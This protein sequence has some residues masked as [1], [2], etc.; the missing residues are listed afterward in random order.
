MALEH[1]I[2]VS[3]NERAGTGYQLTRRFD[4]SI[5]H[6][7]R[8]THQQIYRTLARMADQGLVMF[9]EEPQ[10]GKPDRKVYSVTDGGRAF[11]SEWVTTA[12]KPATLRDELAVKI[13]GARPEDL[14]ALADEI[15]RHREAHAERVDLYRS[16]EKNDYP[17]PSTLTGTALQQQLVLRGG[18][19]IE[20]ALVGWL[21]EVHSALNRNPS[22][23]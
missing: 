22:Q 9:T 7:W 11:L 19:V 1:A 20:E 3:L 13:R 17:D 12:G 18:I 23:P 16:M 14:P 15:H 2:L 10:D 21:D 5:G 8:A 6:F 4:R